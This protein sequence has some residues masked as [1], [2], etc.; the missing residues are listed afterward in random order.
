MTSPASERRS[1]I[2]V[3]DRTPELPRE[4][5]LPAPR[6]DRRKE[7]D[8]EHATATI[9]DLLGECQGPPGAALGFVNVPGLEGEACKLRERTALA[10]RVHVQR[11]GARFIA[12]VGPLFNEQ[13]GSGTRQIVSGTGPLADLRGKGTWHSVRLRGVDSDPTTISFRN[14]WDGV[15]DMDASP[16]TIAVTSS[17]VHS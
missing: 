5:G 6:S 4:R 10:P 12:D 15:A 2:F 8:A 14:T 11:S 16:P 13:D 1:G 7:P 9:A 17:S 3:G